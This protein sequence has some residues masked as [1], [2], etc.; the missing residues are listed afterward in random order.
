MPYRYTTDKS[1]AA[2]RAVVEAGH[3][4]VAKQ[5]NIVD[6]HLERREHI[7]DGGRSIID[8]YSFPMIRWAIKLLPGGLEGYPNLRALHDRLAADPAVRKV[9]ARE[10]G[11]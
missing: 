5:F 7:L 4:L 8:A 6:R 9:L 10:A 2:R 1:E 3:K 11:D